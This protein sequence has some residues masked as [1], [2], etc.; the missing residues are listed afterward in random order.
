MS[1]EKIQKV[2]DG[3]R[4]L[5]NKLAKERKQWDPETADYAYVLGKSAG[6]QAVL[7]LLNKQFIEG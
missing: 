4:A 7:E 2:Y 6:V 5:L 3:I 1:R